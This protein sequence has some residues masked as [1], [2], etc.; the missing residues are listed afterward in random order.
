MCGEGHS[1]DPSCHGAGSAAVVVGQ[2]LARNATLSPLP[3]QEQALS[4]STKGTGFAKHEIISKPCLSH[5]SLC[6]EGRAGQCK[7]ITGIL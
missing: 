2:H 6:V 3:V 4:K 5:I 1:T 7:G